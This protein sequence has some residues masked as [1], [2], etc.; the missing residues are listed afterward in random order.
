[1]H[2]LESTIFERPASEVNWMSFKSA[3]DPHSS[4]SM[5]LTPELVR[6]KEIDREDFESLGSPK[7]FKE[8]LVPCVS[9][10]LA[11]FSCVR[12]SNS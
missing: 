5:E 10:A 12:I 3:V 2:K 4:K 11:S 9:F 1:M 7:W 6:S 8:R